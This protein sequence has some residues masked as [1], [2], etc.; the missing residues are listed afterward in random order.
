MEEEHGTFEVDF[1]GASA[2]LNKA[3]VRL[4]VTVVKDGED[5][6]SREFVAETV[7]TARSTRAPYDACSSVL[8]DAQQWIETLKPV[9]KRSGAAPVRVT[10][11][12]VNGWQRFLLALAGLPVPTHTTVDGPPKAPEPEI[13]DGTATHTVAASISVDSTAATDTVS[14]AGNTTGSPYQLA[15]ELAWTVTFDLRERL[16][17]MRYDLERVR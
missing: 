13:G 7:G 11:V 3:T 14:V 17:D 15:E 16:F 4:T 9:R 12:P 1:G 10:P 6:V 8:R 5:A 2:E